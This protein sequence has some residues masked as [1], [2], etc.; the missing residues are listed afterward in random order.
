MMGLWFSGP[1]YQG[2][3]LARFGSGALERVNLIF[4]ATVAQPCVSVDSLD[5]AAMVFPSNLLKL[6]VIYSDAS[7]LKV[8]VPSL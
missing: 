5:Y 4:E 8:S 1:L 6:S 3:P 2:P 7:L